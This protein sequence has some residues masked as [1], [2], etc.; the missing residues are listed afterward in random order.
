MS[1]TLTIDRDIDLTELEA[2]M[3][4][5][6]LGIEELFETE[7]TEDTPSDEVLELRLESF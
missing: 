1:D 7:P 2:A 5:I 4:G 6:A 3:G